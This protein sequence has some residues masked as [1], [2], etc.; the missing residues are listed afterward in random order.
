MND[1]LRA[2]AEAQEKVDQLQV[3]LRFKSLFSE[4]LVYIQDSM[5]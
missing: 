3:N 4:L 2:K 5:T 1:D